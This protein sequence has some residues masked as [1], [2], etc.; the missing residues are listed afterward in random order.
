MYL[1]IESQEHLDSLTAEELAKVKFIN[2]SDTDVSDIS[3][4]SNCKELIWVWA[5][6][7]KISDLSA[8]ANCKEL[9][10]LVLRHTNVSDISALAN[11][12]DLRYIINV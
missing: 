6:F 12:I 2:M 5:G 8:L 1:K 7:T 10:A 11:C 4:L 3:A 9:R